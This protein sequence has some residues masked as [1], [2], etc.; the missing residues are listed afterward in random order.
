M[1]RVSYHLSQAF[2]PATSTNATWQV[3]ASI[4]LCHH[5]HLQ[6]ISELD[7]S[8]QVHHLLTLSL[9][10]ST[11]RLQLCVR[12]P[13]GYLHLFAASPT[14]AGNQPF[15]PTSIRAIISQSQAHAVFTTASTHSFSSSQFSPPHN[16]TAPSTTCHQTS[17]WLFHTPQPSWTSD[18]LSGHPETF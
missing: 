10:F 13:Q 8:A 6:C 14:I 16:H 3:H 7:H 9:T 5:L 15:A 18:L 17:P 2:G 11:H 1:G 12:T 4:Q